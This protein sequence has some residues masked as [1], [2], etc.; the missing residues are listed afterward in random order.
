M[1]IQVFNLIDKNKLKNLDK[2]LSIPS[3]LHYQTT[4]TNNKLNNILSNFTCNKHNCCIDKNLYN[5]LV[6][7]IKPDKED[8]KKYY[9]QNTKRRNKKYKS[10]RK[11]SKKLLE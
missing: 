10:T 7:N 3:I 1:N 8:N 2:N 4:N 9:K 6:D 11:T 5:T